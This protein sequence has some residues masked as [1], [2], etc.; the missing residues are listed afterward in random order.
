MSWPQDIRVNAS[1]GRNPPVKPAGKRLL[2]FLQIIQNLPAAI[3]ASSNDAI[4]SKDLNGVI[5]SWNKGAELLFGYTADEMV[6]KPATVLIP[7]DRHDEELRILQQIARD[8]RVDPYETIRLRKDGRPLDISLTVSPIKNAKG[9]IIGASKIARDI[10]DRRRAEEQLRQQSARLERMNTVAQEEIERRRHAEEEKE[11]LLNEIKHRVKN[12]LGIVRA[13]ARQ[14]FRAA[15]SAVRE[16]FDARIQALA[17]AHDLLTQLNWASVRV[18]EI[19]ERALDAFREPNRERFEVAGPE[20]RLTANKALRLA[21]VLHELGTNAV[22]YGALST[23]E[24]RVSV[25]WEFADENRAQLKLCWRESKGP[26]VASRRRKGFGST[27][28]ER[29]LEG[30]GSAQL[31]FATSGVTC[32]V[33]LSNESPN[34]NLIRNIGGRTHEGG[35]Q[36]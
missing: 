27:L 16:S 25:K 12:T 26:K 2:H 7:M 9:K 6:G 28:I 14:T 35:D 30:E 24:G 15:P 11:L 31:E 8:D 5:T 10:T 20:A 34:A 36:P 22:K 13:I 4:I 19:V 17:S 3:V 23:M 1:E 21:I 18:Q 29:A 33:C 32:T